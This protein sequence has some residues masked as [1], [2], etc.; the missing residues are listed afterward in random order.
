MSLFREEGKYDF[1][2]IYMS[3][4]K[5]NSKALLHFIYS[6][7]NINGMEVE[8]ITCV[9]DRSDTSFILYDSGENDMKMSIN[10]LK[11]KNSLSNGPFIKIK[12]D[13]NKIKFENFNLV[14]ITSYGS[15]IDNISR[16]VI[17]ILK[18]L[19]S[20]FF[21]LHNKYINYLFISYIRVKLICLIFI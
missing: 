2:N 1:N 10:N 4:I 6:D 17:N 12:G 21:L 9:G 20:F 18:L 7:I 16:K 19:Y 15:I 5:T 8:N 11:I 13:S 3:N 14:N